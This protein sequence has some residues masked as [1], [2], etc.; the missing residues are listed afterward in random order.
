MTRWIRFFFVIL[1][2]IGLGLAYGWV[3]NPTDLA[4]IN[5][6]SLRIDYRTDF[7][8]MVAE[9]YQVDKD[10]LI[11]GQRLAALSDKHPF[12]LVEEAIQFSQK[13]GYSDPDINRMNALLEGLKKVSTEG[14][15]LAP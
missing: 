4:D 10:S 5:L 1:V 9:A 11:A 12:V 14:D 7:V 13:V 15:E 3:I 8:L 6:Q 2:G